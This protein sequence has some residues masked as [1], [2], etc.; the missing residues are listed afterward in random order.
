MD[1]ADEVA[2]T[3]NGASGTYR[4]NGTG[5]CTVSINAMGMISDISQGWVF[6]PDMGAMSSQPDYEYLHYGFWLEQTEDSDGV[7]TY[8]EV[9]TFYGSSEDLADSEGGNTG[10]DSVNGSASYSGDAVGV[11]V[12]DVHTEGG[13]MVVSS[14]SGHFVAA[15]ALTAHFGGS[16]IPEDMHGTVTGSISQF[17]LSGEED[18]DWRVNLMGTRADGANTFSGTANGGGAEGTFNGNFYGAVTV[19]DD[20]TDDVNESVFPSDVAG[21]FDANFSNGS[22]AGAFGAS[23]DD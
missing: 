22:V 20:N 9:T 15:V 16:S 12:R 7:I 17:M 6:V 1:E 11:Y 3:Y 19:D 2:G 8:D 21:Q 14:T 23:Q 4:C 10:L 5:A 18:N 13:G